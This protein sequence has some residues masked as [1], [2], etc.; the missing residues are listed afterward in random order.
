MNFLLYNK[1][2]QIYSFLQMQQVWM[3]GTWWRHDNDDFI[4]S[5]LIGKDLLIGRN[6]KFHYVVCICIN[7]ASVVIYCCDSAVEEP[8]NTGNM[9]TTDHSR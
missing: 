7:L 2:R 5:D 6:Y 1:T 9:A 4:I 8:L 3:C